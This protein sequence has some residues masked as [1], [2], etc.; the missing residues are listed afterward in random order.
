MTNVEKLRIILAS[1][2]L[3]IQKFMRVV[4]KTGNIV[5]FKLNPEQKYLLDNMD[6]YNIVCKSR[7]L[8][9]TT[10][11]CAKSIYLAITKPYTNCL[12]MSYSIDSATQIFD[13]LKELY[14]NLPEC[15]RIPLIANNKK[16][17]AFT[18]HSKIDVMTCGNKDVGR[19][20]TYQY[21]HLSEV[22]F[23]KD[24][25]NKQLLAIE[26]TLTPNAQIILESTAN[27]MNYF[28]ELWNKAEHKESMYKPFFFSW[29]DDK[30]MF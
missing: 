29:I 23:M 18:N 1:P 13:K 3:Y 16:E 5:P 24:T 21:V 4:D 6:K 7:Q 11:S 14:Y 15:I 2:Q 9:I 22:A 19:G 10:L 8:G 28:Y 30:I 12:L 27:G 17:L 26:Q 20:S 25:I